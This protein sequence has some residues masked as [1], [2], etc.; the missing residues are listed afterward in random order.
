MQIIQG[1]PDPC[2]ASDPMLAFVL[3][4]VRRLPIGDRLPPRLPITPIILHLL[5]QLWSSWPPDRQYDASMLWA[6]VCLGFFGFMRAGEFTCPSLQAFNSNNMLGGSDMSVDS[7]DNPRIV[8]VHLCQL[9]NDHSGNGVT[10][11]VG[12][13]DQRIF[14]VVALLIY[15]VKRGTGPG[16]LFQFW[17]GTSLSKQRLVFQVRQALAPRGI[18]CSC[19]TGHSFCIDTA[20]AAAWA[21]V[22]DSIIQTL[23]RWRSSAYLRYIQ[24]PPSM[25]AATSGRLLHN[26]TQPQSRRE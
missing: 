14:P 11:C 9:K 3:R 20:T 5:L 12:R 24:T 22:E 10:V 7:W 16:P 19:L 4:G 18:D 2:L 21:G 1:L 6:A 13:T 8:L 25:L 26:D 15:L 23:G 17:D